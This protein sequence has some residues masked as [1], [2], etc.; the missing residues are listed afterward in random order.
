MIKYFTINENGVSIQC[1]W[2]T[3]SIADIKSVILYCH[4]FGGHKDNKAAERFASHVISKYKK[5]AVLTFDWPAHGNDAHGKLVLKDCDTYLETIVQYLQAM[6]IERVDVYGNSFGGYLVLKY[7]Q[8]HDNPFKKMAFRSPAINM[9]DTLIHHVLNEDELKKI[10]K[11]K[12]VLVGFD[13]KVK[14]NKKYLE[15]VKAV[16]LTKM[17]YIPFADDL[18]VCHGKR[19]EVVSYDIVEKF[20]DDNIIEFYPF[21]DVDH[22]FRN[23][24]KM[25]ECH[26]LFIKFYD[27]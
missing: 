14:I 26:N 19:D 6:Q 1:K 16:D 22:R 27:L 10:E 11:G 24:N 23:Q 21:E 4:G 15:E 17:D 8:E 3:N 2:Y 9:Y 7:I 5:S 18:M 20:C 25:D 13:R 12:D